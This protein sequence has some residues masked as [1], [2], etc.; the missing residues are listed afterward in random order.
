MT[1]ET[2]PIDAPMLNGRPHAG[3]PRFD[4][5]ALAALRSIAVGRWLARLIVFGPQVWGQHETML[6]EPGPGIL[7]LHPEAGPE[8]AATAAGIHVQ[9][10]W[11]ESGIRSGYAPPENPIRHF[12]PRV[13]CGVVD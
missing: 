4:A 13:L 11:L 12:D 10:N 9:Y 8:L 3:V 6:G 7:V 5:S 1:A 2:V